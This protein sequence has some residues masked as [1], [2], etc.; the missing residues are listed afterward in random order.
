M[1]L[2][3]TADWHIGA[4]LGVH[5]RLPDQRA[6]LHALIGV[7][8]HERPDLILHAGDVFD[9]AQ[10]GH[11]ALHTAL[12]ALR[13]M[14]AT[15]TTI[16]IAGNHDS[17]RLLRALDELS[18]VEPRRLRFVTV[19]SVVTVNGLGTDAG[20]TAHIVCVPFVSAARALRALRTEPDAMHRTYAD[21]LDRLHERLFRD[22]AAERERSG[23]T[24]LHTGHLYVDGAAVGKSER[25]VTVSTAYASRRRI[26]GCRAP[27]AAYAALGHIHEPQ[28]VDTG[29]GGVHSHYPGS[30]VPGD[31]GEGEAPRGALIVDVEGGGTTVRQAPLPTGRR[32]LDFEGNADELHRAAAGGA[33]NDTLVRAVVHSDERIYDLAEQLFARS[34]TAAVHELT[35]RVRNDETRTATDY[36]WRDEPEP[37]LRTLYREWRETRMPDEREPDA[38]AAALFATAL[39]EGETPSTTDFG[40]T[41]AAADRVAKLRERLHAALD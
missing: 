27:A 17:F 12:W 16:V 30:L 10:P 21:H 19:P 24:V 38:D 11:D 32:L 14:A 26:L 22:A 18:A 9:A 29:P 6:A 2:L 7:A 28:A 25:R 5:E 35:N 36:R 33:L 40:G 4:R 13:A 3:H 31:F 15:A 39:A 23:G 37:D 34:P 20:E 1:R 41:A 8:E